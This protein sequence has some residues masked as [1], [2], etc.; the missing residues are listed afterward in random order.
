MINKGSKQYL[1]IAS[2]LLIGLMLNILPLP[3]QINKMAP[4]WLLMIL[5]FWVIWAPLVI[6]IFT[7]FT[8]G[9]LLDLL[10]GSILGEHAF[11]F[12]VI[13]YLIVK[14]RR[15]LINHP[16]LQQSF[17]IFLFVLV[18]QAI[19]VAIQAVIGQADIS[20]SF[21]LASLTSAIFWSLV[22]ILLRTVQVTIA[23]NFSN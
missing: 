23:D 16:L 22:C 9:I 17:F 11:A 6:N 3:L 2:T 15:T 14:L 12:V 8:V 5:I 10:N 1:V 20:S 4:H 13:I 18:Y 21:W 19:I 7:A